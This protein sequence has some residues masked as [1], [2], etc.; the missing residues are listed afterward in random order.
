MP[1][2]APTRT[3]IQL[4]GPS[5]VFVALSLNGGEMLLWP[6][7]VGRFGLWMLW[8]IPIILI[9]QFA[10]NLEIERY[11]ITT[12]KNTLS[13]LIGINRFIRPLFIV[14]IIISLGWPAWISTAGN[15]LAFSLGFGQYGGWLSV[16]LMLALL[17]L[18]FSRASYTIIENL[19]KISLITILGISIFTIFSL[20]RLETWN[21]SLSQIILLPT[22]PADKFTF[23]SALA[24]GGVAGVLNL[25]Q[26]D[27]VANRNY[28]LAGHSNPDQVDL[29]S[30]ESKSNWQKWWRLI[31]RE[32]FILFYIG[33]LVGITLISLVGAMTLTGISRSGFGILTYQVSLL[34]IDFGYLGTLWAVAIFVLFVMAQMTIL[35]AAGRLL[36]R[37]F[38]HIKLKNAPLQSLISSS[39]SLSQIF[40]LI[41][42]VVL[43][44]TAII[45]GF[46]Q[47]SILLQ[48]SATLSAL[49]MVFYPLLL[50][51]LNSNLPIVARPKLWN[52]VLILSC[53]IFYAGFLTWGLIG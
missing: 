49:I 26:S 28:G 31:V 42:V 47:P 43:I 33:N 27:W 44:G 16:I 53:V 19:A 45:P 36:K 41:G 22:S 3:L 12:G 20:F 17:T 14:G 2:P 34:N 30:D 21:Q 6:D 25:V 18:W 13:G 38:E 4:L 5:I 11:T 46:N 40:G 1:F 10:V 9:L 51:K 7:L 15:V 8:P 37:C 48:I 35:D 39:S 23:V 52:R 32:H 29:D 50:L 24:F